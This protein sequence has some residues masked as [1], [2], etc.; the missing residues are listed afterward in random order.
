[1]KV[2][3]KLYLCT[4]RKFIYDLLTHTTSDDCCCCLCLYYQILFLMK[5]W[6]GGGLRCTCHLYL[7]SGNTTAY[8]FFSMQ[9]YW[10]QTLSGFN[11]VSSAHRWHTLIC[12]VGMCTL[13]FTT[14][15]SSLFLPLFISLLFHIE[16]LW[17]FFFFFQIHFKVIIYTLLK[18]ISL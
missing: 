11:F 12:I 14:I 13:L 9:L 3:V 16:E 2:H 7:C 15:G 5:P 10:Y 17:F 6:C 8:H 18:D 4:Q 1:M